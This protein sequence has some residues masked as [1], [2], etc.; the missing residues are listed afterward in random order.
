MSE[1]TDSEKLRDGEIAIR[2]S[3]GECVTFNVVQGPC[4]VTVAKETVM[5]IQQD[6]HGNNIADGTRWLPITNCD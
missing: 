4:Q 6:E 1:K 3:N 5:I 2:W